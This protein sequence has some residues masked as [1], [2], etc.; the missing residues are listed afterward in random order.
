MGS[1][2][3][4]DTTSFL[5]FIATFLG[6]IFIFK[7]T[8]KGSDSRLPPGPR[9]WPIIGSLP[10][11]LGDITV[12]LGELRDIYGDVFTIQMGPRPT[13]VLASYE[14]TKEAFVKQG[15]AFSGRPQDDFIT[16]EIAQGKGTKY[17]IQYSC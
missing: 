8:N 11:M 10:S 14:A 1:L 7:K 15:G 5:V 13:V 17:K 16:K 9:K 4:L 12:R 3:T 6:G 2:F